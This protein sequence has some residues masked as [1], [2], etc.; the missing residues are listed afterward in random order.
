MSYASQAIARHGGVTNI[1]GS[2]AEAAALLRAIDKSIGITDNTIMFSITLGMFPMWKGN[3]SCG[4][5]REYGRYVPGSL[6][7]RPV[8]TEYMSNKMYRIETDLD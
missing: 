4:R 8:E 5:G 6:Q 2:A 7:P 1:A 3:V